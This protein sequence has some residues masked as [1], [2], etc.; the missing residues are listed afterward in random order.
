MTTGGVLAGV[1]G[2]W[3]LG[4]AAALCFVGMQDV[5]LWLGYGC[6]GVEARF[7]V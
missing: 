4:D 1:S 7:G 6:L 3:L 5:T 2:G